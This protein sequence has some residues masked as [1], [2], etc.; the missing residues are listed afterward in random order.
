MLSF[1]RA[2]TKNSLKKTPKTKE[3]YSSPTT[4]QYFKTP[5]ILTHAL[6]TNYIKSRLI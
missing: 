4:G 3:H 5:V 2:V 1:E 6:S